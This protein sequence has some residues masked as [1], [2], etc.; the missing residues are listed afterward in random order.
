MPRATEPKER[1]EMTAT[2]TPR[3]IRPHDF[4]GID[5]LLDDE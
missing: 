5:D 3:E 1:P 4:L 2:T